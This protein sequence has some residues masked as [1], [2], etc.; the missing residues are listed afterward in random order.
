VNS[1]LQNDKGPK[2]F[3]LWGP[4]APTWPGVSSLCGNEMASSLAL[5]SIYS[6]SPG[7]T[8]PK[9]LVCHPVGVHNGIGYC[10]GEGLRNAAEGRIYGNSSRLQ[11]WKRAEPKAAGQSAAQRSLKPSQREKSLGKSYSGQ[12]RPTAPRLE[13]NTARMAAD[14]GGHPI[15]WRQSSTRKG[16]ESW[17]T[18]RKT[19]GR[20]LPR[21]R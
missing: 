9:D 1:V 16:V 21:P 8:T 15:F 10:V 3:R 11:T 12:P 6:K 17:E 2:A 5:P 19:D 4:C 20:H 13:R 14:S 7:V 18:V